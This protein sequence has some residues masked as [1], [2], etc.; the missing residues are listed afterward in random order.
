[1]S[2]DEEGGPSVVFATPWFRIEELPARPEWGIGGEPF[3]RLAAPDGV[4]VVAVDQDGR[5]LLVRQYRPSRGRVSLELPAGEIGPGETPA[6]AARR[7][8]I[9]ETGHDCAELLAL[10]S[11]GL[12]VNRESSSTH[13]F[14]ARGLSA[15]GAAEYEVVRVRPRE[16]PALMADGA[17]EHLA[18]LGALL[19]AHWR[20]GIDLG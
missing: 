15:V 20:A 9:E 7:E 19:L 17:F 2:G 18:G 6:I 1:M 8:L 5:L 12:A 16:V 11:G 4:T 3:Y 10:G 14:L 13:A